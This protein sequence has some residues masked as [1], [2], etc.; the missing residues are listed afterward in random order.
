MEC[1]FAI[2]LWQGMGG[3]CWSIGGGEQFQHWS[4]TS[5][6]ALYG[7]QTSSSTI[8]GFILILL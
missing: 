3:I 5:K 2:E 6:L 7:L 1:K 8:E 4:E